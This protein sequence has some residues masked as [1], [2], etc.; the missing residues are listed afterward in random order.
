MNIELPSRLTFNAKVESR[1]AFMFNASHSYNLLYFIH[2]YK[3][4]GN[5][6]LTGFT[7]VNQMQEIVFGI[8]TTSKFLKLVY[9]TAHEIWDNFE[10]S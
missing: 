7:C 2:A 10:I 4:S 6:H 5:S 9:I 8:N 1:S 3:A